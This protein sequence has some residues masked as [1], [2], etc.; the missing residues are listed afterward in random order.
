MTASYVAV[1]AKVS[2]EGMTIMIKICSLPQ[3]VHSMSIS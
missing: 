1:M 3:F 2:H